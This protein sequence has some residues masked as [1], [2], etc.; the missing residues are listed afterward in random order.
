MK[1]FLFLPVLLIAFSWASAQKTILDPNAELRSVKGFH[2]V[3]VSNG[4]D[5]YLSSGDEALAVSGSTSDY[6][7]H[8]KTSVEN[9]VL[10]IWY[11]EDKNRI[12]FNNKRAL[13][14][15]LSYKAL[16]NIQAS[17]G[18]DVYIDGTLKA[19]SLV[20]SISG[21]SDFKGKIDADDLKIEQSGGSDINIEGA[22]NS[23]VI[24]ASGGS[25]FNGY[26]FISQS[27]SVEASGGSDVHI[28]VTKDLS[29]DASGGSDVLYK[30]AATLKKNKAIGSNVKKVG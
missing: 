4:I 8:I 7:A 26:D 15:Y 20:V 10:K 2:A 13:K 23:V 27:C 22:A 16:D 12:V 14:A 9:G 18:S 3:E 28:T 6:T 17:G 1:K 11:E 25:D 19:K 21:G 29:A 24:S 5:L 30:G